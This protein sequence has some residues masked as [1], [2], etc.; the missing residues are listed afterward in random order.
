MTT[1]R[2]VRVIRKDEAVAEHGMVTAMHPLAAEAGVEILERG[3]NAVDAAIATALAVAV[4]EPFMNGLGGCCYA[5][6]HEKRS[7]RTFCV[8]GSAVAPAAAR[9]DLFELADPSEESVGLYGWPATKDQASETGYRAPC[10]PGTPAALGLLHREGGS[11]PWATLFEPARRLA[12]GYPV[13]EYVFAQ[14]AAS[15][16]RLSAFP[17]TLAVFFGAGGTLLAPSFKAH[18]PT[19]LRQPA[20][21]ATLETLAEEGADA[22]YTGALARAAVDHLSE[23]GGLLTEDD[24]ASYEARLQE[25]LWC[26]Y[27][28]HRVAT[29]PESS[30]GPTLACALSLLDGFEPNDDAARSVHLVAEALRL[31]FLDRFEF[32]GDRDSVPVPLAGLL[33][34]G[35]L[36]ERRRLIEPDGPS[37]ADVPTGDP[38][39]HDPGAPDALPGGADS[40]D[41]HTTH[42]NVVDGDGNF[43]ALTGTLGGRYGSGVTVPAT[44]VVLNNGM[45][46]FDPE[47]GKVASLAAGKRALHAAAPALLFDGDGPRAAVGSPGGRMIMSAVAQVLVHLVDRGVGIQDAIETPRVHREAAR[48]VSLDSRFPDAVR[49][50]LV[51]RGH[52]IQTATES[53]MSA[54]FGRPSGIRVEPTTGRLHGGVEPYRVSAA[55]GF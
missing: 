50:G 15:A 18:A 5:V 39:R 30:G 16:S 55:V 7:G 27:R 11:I 33:S 34:D 51:A 40:P 22:F 49:E 43:V 19:L 54:Y 3:G 4:V 9:E 42:L 2:S 44:G 31:A 24:Y 13:D 23:R 35:Y 29:L 28:D 53:F 37:P 36:S 38:W 8:D 41:Q 10:V 25:P 46:W 17:E 20:L 45:M 32:L 26:A 14:T 21:G 6:V 1:S 47:P 48:K 12:E 52:E